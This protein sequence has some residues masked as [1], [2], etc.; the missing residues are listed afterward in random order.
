MG[1]DDA[2]GTVIA[3]AWPRGAGSGA[4]EILSPGL[5]WQSFLTQLLRWL[6]P[7]HDARWPVAVAVALSCIFLLLRGPGSGSKHNAPGVGGSE[8][9]PMKAK[10]KSTG[11][12]GREQGRGQSTPGSPRC[13]KCSPSLAALR[14]SLWRPSSAK[15]HAAISLA[16]GT[17]EK[18]CVHSI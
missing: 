7:W 17:T 2:L 8:G 13:K 9:V 16:A 1:R 11:G 3:P 6:P 12:E 18:A 14:A 4:E 10:H 15:H 5:S